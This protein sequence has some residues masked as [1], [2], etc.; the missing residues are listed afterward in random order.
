MSYA[1]QLIDVTKKFGNFYAND[2]INLAVKKGEVH[3][4]LGENGA[5]KSTLM[6]LLYGI[7]NLDSGIIKINEQEVKITNPAIANKFK[8]GMVHQH[9]KLIK[10]FTILENIILGFEETD[11]FSFINDQKAKNELPKLIEKYNFQLDINSKV[12]DLKV[13][14]Q[15]KVEILKMLYKKSDILIFDEPTGA[16]TPQEADELLQI[17]K[18]LKEQGKTIILITHKLKE[19]KKIADKCTVIRKGKTIDTVLVN[20][21]DE[22][23]LADMMVGRA[24]DFSINKQE[25]V[26]GEKILTVNDLNYTNK[27]GISRLRNINLE[28]YRG[29]IVG[30]AGIDGN[31]QFEL[32][33][34]INSTKKVKK[35]QINYLNQDITKMSIRNKIKAGIATIEQDRQTDGLILDYSILENSILKDYFN[36]PFNKHK[37][38]NKDQAR[39]KAKK[40]VQEYDVRI[41]KTIDYP[42][43]DLSGGNQQKL[44]IGREISTNHQLLLAVGPTRGVDVGA[45]EFIHNQLIEERSKGKSILLVSLEL[46]EIMKLSDR[47]IVMHDGEIMGE[48]SSSEA[49]ENKI[50][51]MMAGKK[52]DNE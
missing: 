32:V 6:N 8:I 21:F 31:G 15:Q 12:K 2:Q 33:G 43:R 52:V 47:I 17:I 27:L 25:V 13:G 18:K 28:L 10:K 30:L 4:I 36:Y 1:V 5:G 44:I 48:L 50:G 19:I 11:H 34:A 9:F 49:T 20:N 45:I 37:I 41:P 7:Y 38:L 29:E 23:D 22:Q 16:L 35:G 42:V 3:A 40:I 14:E 51:L 46:E 26:R 39:K 24:V